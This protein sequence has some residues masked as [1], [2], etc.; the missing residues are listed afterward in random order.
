MVVALLA[1]SLLVA[2]LDWESVALVSDV[3]EI[4]DSLPRPALPDLSGLSVLIVPALSLAIVG[5]V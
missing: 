4:P 1:S 5:L 3:A 2:F